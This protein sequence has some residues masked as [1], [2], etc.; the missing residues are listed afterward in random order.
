MADMNKATES[1]QSAI[2]RR[3]MEL[4][5]QPALRGYKP[6]G[7]WI[8]Q[9][10][11]ELAAFVVAMQE[12]DILTVLEV[13]TGEGGLARFMHHELG[14]Q[15]TTVD[16]EK[17]GRFTPETLGSIHFLQI[18]SKDINEPGGIFLEKGTT[19]DLVFI[20]AGH[21]YEDLQADFDKFAPLATKAIALHDISGNWGCDGVERWWKEFAY[22]TKGNLR[23]GCHEILA[24]VAPLGIG[25]IEVK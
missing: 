25:W 14:W 6:D 8:H 12:R 5:T 9:Q 3:I 4:G 15:V 21:S 22:T 13:G 7:W 17:P 11:D 1:N 20:D 10:P 16:R 18:D 19:F 23:K 24:E 2:E